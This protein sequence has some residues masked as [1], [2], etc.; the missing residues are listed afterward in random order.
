MTH[1]TEEEHPFYGKEVVRRSE[2]DYIN[3]LLKKYKNDPVNDTLQAKIWDELQMEKHYGRITI[4]FK[5]V[6]RRDVTKKFPDYIEV[7]LDTKV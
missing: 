5:V 7:I 4:P 1:D 2:Q 3:L 6:M